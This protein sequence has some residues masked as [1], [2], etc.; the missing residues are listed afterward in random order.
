MVHLSGVDARST[1]VATE[2]RSEVGVWVAILHLELMAVGAARALHAQIKV[3]HLLASV[4]AS[5]LGDLE[6]ISARVADQFVALVDVNLP[7]SVSAL[8][9]GAGREEDDGVVLMTVQSLNSCACLRRSLDRVLG[10]QSTSRAQ[11]IVTGLKVASKVADVLGHTVPATI[12]GDVLASL[13][14]TLNIS[15]KWLC[16][17]R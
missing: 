7:L 13:M 14:H 6:L 2:V 5:A 11:V 17:E 3:A 16:S 4:G 10:T 9:S 15:R 1:V 12:T 8:L